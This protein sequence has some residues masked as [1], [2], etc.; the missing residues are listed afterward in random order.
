MRLPIWLF[1]TALF[2]ATSPASQAVDTAPPGQVFTDAWNANAAWGSWS[3][4]INKP[5]PISSALSFKG[6]YSLQVTYNQAWAG[7][8]PGNW[9]GFSTAGYKHITFAV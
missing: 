9:K 1:L 4:N 7:F 5:E 8:A 6:A 3:W 2:L